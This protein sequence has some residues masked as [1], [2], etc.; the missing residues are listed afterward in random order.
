MKKYKMFLRFL[1]LFLAAVLLL[2]LCVSGLVGKDIIRETVETEFYTESS[3]DLLV[4]IST[5]EAFLLETEIVSE[6]ET[7]VV[8]DVIIDEIF[9]AE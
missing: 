7:A 5:E 2:S 4:D 1:P 3:E 6:A 9:P 8:A